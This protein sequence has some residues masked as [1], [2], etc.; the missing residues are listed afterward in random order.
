MIT[1]KERL[2]TVR[3]AFVLTTYDDAQTDLSRLME[4]VCF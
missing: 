3:L 1:L 4:T 2:L